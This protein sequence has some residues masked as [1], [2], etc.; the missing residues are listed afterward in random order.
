MTKAEY[1]VTKIKMYSRKIEVQSM[2]Y[3]EYL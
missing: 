1:L 3:F 2:P